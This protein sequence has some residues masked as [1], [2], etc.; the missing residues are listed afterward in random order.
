MAGVTAYLGLG[1][2]L[3]D[4]KKNLLRG[5]EFLQ[6][7]IQ[8]SKVSPTYETD[9][10]GYTEQPPFLN[11]VCMGETNLSPLDLLSFAKEAEAALG[12]VPTF[13]NGPRTLDVDILFYGE[14]VVS[15]EAPL[16]KQGT[17]PSFPKGMEEG[18]LE[19]PHP[20]LPERKFVLEPLAD[21]AP[22]LRH[23]VSGATVKEMFEHLT[24]GGDGPP[25]AD[26]R[27]WTDIEVTVVRVIDGDSLMV[28]Y[29]DGGPPFELRLHG[30]D[31]REYDQ[32][33]GEVAKASLQRLTA[34]RRFRLSV[35]EPS[36]RYSRSV[37]ILYSQEHRNSINHQMVEAGMAYAYPPFGS[38]NG[39]L[40]CRQR[41]EK[42]KLGIWAQPELPL[43]PSI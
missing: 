15:V 34:N 39:I 7:Q 43:D 14:E 10:V 41:A 38:L 16:P 26:K 42:N 6:K 5:I 23:P 11:C 4:R 24:E 19:V 13:R 18:G 3:G 21:I 1:S 2:N 28:R 8:I 9:P 40:A 36:D 29:V 32:S 31:A 30:I 37:G 12:R 27:K 20:R 25:D 17:L 33:F 35:I 22:D